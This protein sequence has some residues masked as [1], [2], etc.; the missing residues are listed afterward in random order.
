MRT[1]ILAALMIVGAALAA[2]GALGQA[3]STAC[4]Y[5]TSE[6]KVIC[7]GPAFLASEDFAFML[8]E[9]KGTYCFVGGGPGKMVHHPEYRFNPDILP[10]GAAYWVALVENYLR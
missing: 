10:A 3:N 8:Q 4:T 6:G 1:A 9:K 7:P 2:M 5:S